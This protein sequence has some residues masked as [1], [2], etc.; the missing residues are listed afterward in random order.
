[1][2]GLRQGGKA[3]DRVRESVLKIF[4]VIKKDGGKNPAVFYFGHTVYELN[5]V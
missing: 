4:D 5:V 3:R 2:R 1:M